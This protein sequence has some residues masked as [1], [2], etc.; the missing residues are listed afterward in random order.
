MIK[1][2]HLV[3]RLAGRS[4]ETAWIEAAI[5][6][7]DWTEQDPT[8]PSLTRSFKAIAAAGGKIIR[9]VHRPEG[10]DVL[11]VTAFFDRGAKR[12]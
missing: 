2:S 6:A 5:E 4:L 8:D 10:D 12:P 3:K 9:V 11:V 1:T 7:A